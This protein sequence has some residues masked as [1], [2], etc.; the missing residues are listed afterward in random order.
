[1]DELQQHFGKPSFAQ[2]V[3]GSSI[4]IT[5]NHAVSINRN[6]GLY[7]TFSLEKASLVASGMIFKKT[8][9]E[10]VIS[11]GFPN[12]ILCLQPEKEGTV[13]VAAQDEAAFTTETRDSIKEINELLATNPK[14]TMDEITKMIDKRQNELARRNPFINWYRIY[15]EN[16]RIEKLSLPPLGGSPLREGTKYD[17][18]R[19]MPDG[20]VQHG[21]ITVK[22]TDETKSQSDKNQINIDLVKAKSD[23]K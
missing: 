3:F 17:Y 7:W 15:P 18:F 2:L 9:P 14:M 13:L 16:G 10:Q 5:E 8:T 6:T 12:A 19:P 1:M 22:K 4:V 21:S 11:G 20:S 23:S